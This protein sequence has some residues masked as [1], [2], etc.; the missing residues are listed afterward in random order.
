MVSLPSLSGLFGFFYY[1]A[2]WFG[3]L[4]VIGPSLT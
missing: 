1:S 3:A 2:A 4:A